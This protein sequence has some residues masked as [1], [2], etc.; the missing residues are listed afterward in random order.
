[1]SE[2]CLYFGRFDS[3]PKWQVDTMFTTLQSAQDCLS[4]DITNQ[5]LNFLDKGILSQTAYLN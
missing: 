5:V 4:T 3:N 2:K 1:M